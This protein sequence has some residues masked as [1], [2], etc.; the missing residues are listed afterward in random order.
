M[1]APMFGLRACFNFFW[2]GYI[3]GGKEIKKKATLKN[4]RDSAMDLDSL[5]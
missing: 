1:Y 2:P 4:E 3:N 5:E